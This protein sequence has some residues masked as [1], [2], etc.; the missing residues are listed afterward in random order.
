[1]FRLI[2]SRRERRRQRGATLFS[3]TAHTVAIVT[4]AVNTAMGDPPPPVEPPDPTPILI[5][6][7][8]DPSTPPS[9]AT[10]TTPAHPAPGP[11]TIA[12]PPIDIPTRIPP[13]GDPL[14]VE[15]VI[16]PAPTTTPG[17]AT[18]TTGM[19]IGGRHR[20]STALWADEV[21]RAAK[22]LGR[23]RTPRYPDILQRARQEGS[24]IASF[25][26]DTLGRVEPASFRAAASTHALFTESVRNAVLT[27]RFRPAEVAGRPVRQL[28]EQR[29]VF[30]LAP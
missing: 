6:I 10:P 25:V 22:P 17:G 29:F 16:G 1:M 26:V 23:T 12:V 2:E 11:L 9:P 4:L 24:V 28:V 27:M 5:P 21:E 15:P 20:D 13:I 8:T 30:S 7:E 14:P 19:S 3:V 18:T